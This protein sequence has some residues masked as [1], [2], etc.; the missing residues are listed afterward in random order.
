MNPSDRTK[1]LEVVLGFA[2]LKGK[3]L[4]A[5]ALELYWRAMR[6]WDLAEFQAAAERLLKT[7]EFMP[8]PKDFEDLRSATNLCASEAWTAVLDHAKVGRYRRAPMDNLTETVIRALG[9]WRQIAMCDLSELHWLEK[10]FRETY[11][12]LRDTH[13]TRTALR[14]SVDSVP[15]AIPDLRP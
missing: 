15:F 3:Q 5:P 11:E 10:R 12:E 13:A 14:I 6:D 2:E 9:G 4:S 1:F 7:S 8:T